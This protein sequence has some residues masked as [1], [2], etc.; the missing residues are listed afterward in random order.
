MS[1]SK[2]N[3]GLTPSLLE[4]SS[5]KALNPKLR[6]YLDSEESQLNQAKLRGLNNGVWNQF[7]PDATTPIMWMIAANPRQDYLETQVFNT[8]DS[9]ALRW[10]TD[11]PNLCFSMSLVPYPKSNRISE[12]CSK[13][14]QGSVIIKTTDLPAGKYKIL[15]KDSEQLASELH[16]QLLEPKESQY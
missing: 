1:S 5:I 7:I 13:G 2:I 14:K 15:F 9:I 3:F 6:I 10:Q 11:K 4:F 12:V 8:N 16:F